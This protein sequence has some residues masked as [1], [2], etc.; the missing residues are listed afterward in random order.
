MALFYLQQRE[1]RLEFDYAETLA[2]EGGAETL[3]I[4][5]VTVAN[6][7]RASIDEVIA[8]VSVAPGQIRQA[9]VLSEVGITFEE[10]AS[11]GTYLVSFSFMN[12]GGRRHNFGTG[13]S[14]RQPSSRA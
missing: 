7:G 6:R 10:T 13:R 4:Y 5:H 9:R 8:N 12:P 3:A 11:G 14:P 2:F 1:P